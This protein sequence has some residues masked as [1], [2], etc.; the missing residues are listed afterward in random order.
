MPTEL[1]PFDPTRNVRRLEQDDESLV[2]QASV[3]IPLVLVGL[4]ASLPGLLVLPIFAAMAATASALLA[5][6]SSFRLFGLP[7]ASQSVRD[8]TRVLAL[9][10]FGAGMMTDFPEVTK[11]IAG[12]Y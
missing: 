11:A 8:L 1:P 12:S 5:V 2:S 6:G 9:V 3:V 7:P 10:G 4:I